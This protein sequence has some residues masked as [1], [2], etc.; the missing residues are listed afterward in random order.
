MLRGIGDVCYLTPSHRKAFG[1]PAR[2][3]PAHAAA[4]SGKTDLSACLIR[5][6]GAMFLTVFNDSAVHDSAMIRRHGMGIW[7]RGMA[8][9]F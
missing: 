5:C 3:L 6:L 8:E 4:N 9:S 1:K 2:R 7:K